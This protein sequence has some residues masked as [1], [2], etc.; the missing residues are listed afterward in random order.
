MVDKGKKT[1]LI[2]AE[3]SLLR[4]V[5]ILRI[6]LLLCFVPFLTEVITFD[7]VETTVYISKFKK[8]KGA[9]NRGGGKKIQLITTETEK[10]IFL[11]IYSPLLNFLLCTFSKFQEKESVKFLGKF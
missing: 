9:L 10:D 2:T 7:R 8:N 4:K 5:Y 1:Q 11:R 3:P 6:P